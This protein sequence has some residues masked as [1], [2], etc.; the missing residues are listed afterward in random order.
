MKDNLNV[1][2][3]WKMSLTSIQMLDDH[4]LL[5]KLNTSSIIRQTQE[6]LN[7]LDM[8]KVISTF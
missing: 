8:L 4:H 6:D 1:L 7:P 2:G 5:D 3:R